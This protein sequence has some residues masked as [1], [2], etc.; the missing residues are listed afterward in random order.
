MLWVIALIGAVWL[1]IIYPLQVLAS[2]KLETKQTEENILNLKK[3][4][5]DDLS[6]E[7][8]LQIEK[9]KDILK[10][11]KQE[12]DNFAKDLQ[13]KA[14][15]EESIQNQKCN[16]LLQELQLK[17]E[18]N[19]D[20]ES[21]YKKC[22]LDFEKIIR[23]KCNY[24]PQLSVIMADLLTLYY[25]R[26]ARILET[27]KPPAP[28]EAYR[29]RTL[30]QDTKKILA[31]HKEL[32]Y[33][34]DLIKKQV[35]NIEDLYNMEIVPENRNLDEEQLYDRAQDYMSKEEYMSLSTIERNQLALDNYIKKEKSNWEL[36]RDYELFVGHYYSKKGYTIKYDGILKR[37]QDMGR[38]IIAHNGVETLIIQCKR[39]AKHK[40]I[41][42]NHIFQLYGTLI[43]Y[44]IVNPS[45]LD[46]KGVMIT[47][48]ELSETARKVANHLNID[49][50]NNLKFE[51]FPRIKCNINKR[52]KEKIYH[53]PFDQQYDS[54][55]I[56]EKFGECF[57]STVEE[58]EM[59]GFRRA[60]KHQY[61][62]E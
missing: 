33:K 27:K 12:L 22:I 31:E 44:K 9:E 47:S 2:K 55:V 40:V 35:P 46:I 34:F 19:K 1:L 28:S 7:L 11:K 3:Q 62:K 14:Q 21:Y 39:W 30:R 4:N 54:T 15:K 25:E 16:N 53:L 13:L 24:Y 52:T 36:G 17:I 29:I 59:L 56:E 61:K 57:C 23:E 58:A 51:E 32:Q 6:K 10:L 48:T 20:L 49:I 45:M 26:S 60:F 43:L 38:D 18:Q 41:H 8:Q 37:Y 5:F 50:I 42:E